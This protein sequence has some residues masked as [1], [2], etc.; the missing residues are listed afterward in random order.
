MNDNQF[1]FRK[2][3]STIDAALKC[4]NDIY[5]NDNLKLVTSAIFIDYKKASG[6]I[7]HIL[8]T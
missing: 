2:N 3:K 5:I 1:G 7:S 8:F 6:S 4:V